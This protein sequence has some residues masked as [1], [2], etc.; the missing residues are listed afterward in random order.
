MSRPSNTARMLLSSIAIVAA[1]AALAG[2]A[3]ASIGGTAAGSFTF[4]HDAV[5]PVGEAG[6]NVFLNEVATIS[7]TGGLTGIA[8]A[9]DTIVVHAD[10]SING[11]GTETCGSCTI[12]GRIGSFTAVFTFHGSG[13]Q[14]SGRE[15][16]ISSTGGLAG[17]H[18]GGQFQGSPP[19]L[20]YSYDYG[21]T[22]DPRQ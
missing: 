8:N 21:F 6:G 10:G 13:G 11:H 19:S 12:A 4:V 18:G 1:S 9:T 3:A 17:L 22:P 16:F 5:T 20:T 7:Y 15:T 2:P 14:I